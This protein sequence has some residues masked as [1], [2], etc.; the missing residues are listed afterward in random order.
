MDLAETAASPAGGP[1][2]SFSAEFLYTTP[3]E[4]SK[5]AGAACAP[6]CIPANIINVRLIG[7]V[8]FTPR[9]A[10]LRQIK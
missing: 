5:G 8:V 4:L 2:F 3:G 9:S 1:M 10:R 7:Y 6:N